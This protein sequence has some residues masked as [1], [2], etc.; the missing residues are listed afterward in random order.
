LTAPVVKETWD[1][2]GAVPLK[3]SPAEFDK[4]LRADIEKWPHVIEVSGMQ[5]Q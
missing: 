4:F 1:K 2:Q 3:M 5:T